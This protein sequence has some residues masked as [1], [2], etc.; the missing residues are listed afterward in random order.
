VT[1]TAKKDS[2]RIPLA[3]PL[4]PQAGQLSE[5]YEQVLSL[6]NV[7]GCFV[8]RRRR[9]GRRTREIALVACVST[10]LSTRKLKRSQ[11]VPRRLGW[12]V[13]SKRTARL[14]TDVQV[15]GRSELHS[16]VL[17]AGDEIDGYF[18]PSGQAIESHGTIGIA[19][20]HPIYGRVVTTAAHVFVGPNYGETTLPPGQEWRVL[21]RCSTGSPVRNG[22]VHKM[23]ITHD[24]D[25]A[26][27]SPPPGVPVENLYHDSQPLGPPYVPD[28]SD[29]D[30]PA[31]VLSVEKSHLTF[32]RGYHGRITI[33]GLELRD[34]L[35]TDRRT[36]GG[37]SGACLVTSG[38][39]P[40]GL[41]EG[42]TEIDGESV[43]VFTSIVW[44]L[45]HEKATTF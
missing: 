29:L 9:K 2:L 26:I 25:Y 34:V 14:R 41:V 13:T 11:R 12:A 22:K 7:V 10:K 1:P 32:L 43:S 45:L 28:A 42:G 33:E 44:P 6:P 16:T 20:Q 3:A 19:M 30:K 24:C 39:R 31:Y 40:M 23:V 4:V 21:L 17:G 36:G 18:P 37:D 5:M 38:S 35:I 27:V 8:G 15:M